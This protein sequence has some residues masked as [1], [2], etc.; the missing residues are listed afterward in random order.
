MTDPI[1]IRSAA[2]SARFRPDVGF[3]CESLTHGGFDYLS[4]SP[5]DGPTAGG[6]PVLFPWPNRIAGA[7]WS[8]R[9]TTCELPVNEPATGASLH[10][11]A[12]HRPWR[13]LAT[14]PD[15]VT[16]EF[17]ISRDSPNA[18]WPADAGL[19]L[20]YR[21]SPGR[22]SATAEV[23][24]P[25]DRDLPYG[26]GFHPYLRV[27]G[28]FGT[29]ELQV[30][31]H[32]HWPLTPGLVPVGHTEPVD[33]RTDFNRARRLGDARLDDVLTALPAASGLA[34][35]AML[36]SPAAALHLSSDP[37]FRE[38]VLYTPPG[39]DAVAVEPY[40][41]ASDAVNLAQRGVDAGWRVLPAGQVDRLHWSIEIS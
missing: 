18:S 10:G 5:D 14:G 22:L 1:E 33:A 23:F 17:L 27:P 40:T 3:N 30:S 19:R 34:R 24:S 31:A 38:Y 16:C 36:R 37:A 28:P 29:W 25:E 6:I 12:C 7:S 15:R 8:W 35:R 2:T 11:Y 20:T 32:A 13:V 4:G 39:R 21:V 9:G 41:C 26:L